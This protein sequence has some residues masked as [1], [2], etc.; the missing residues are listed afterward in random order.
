MRSKDVSGQSGVACGGGVRPPARAFR[1][2]EEGASQHAPASAPAH[3]PRGA[4]KNARRTRPAAC[5]VRAWAVQR[6]RSALP[7][8]GPAAVRRS[9]GVR[10]QLARAASRTAVAVPVGVAAGRVATVQAGSSC[11]SRNRRT[12]AV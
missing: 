7:S 5:E 10:P 6:G 12:A 11:P 3:A 2:T 9:S 4:P 1:A 8:I